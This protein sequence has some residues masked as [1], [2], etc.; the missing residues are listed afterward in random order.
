MNLLDKIARNQFL[1]QLFPTGLFQPIHIGQINLDIG[2][3]VYFSLHT[4]QKPEMEVAKWGVWG[5]DYNTI[6]IK[7]FAKSGESIE[8]KEWRNLHYDILTV[9]ENGKCITIRQKSNSFSLKLEVSNIIFQECTT[10]ADE[11]EI[12]NTKE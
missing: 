11:L 9:E 2:G 3:R 6:V 1:L 10:Y 8:I 4:R 7:L 12:K 5:K